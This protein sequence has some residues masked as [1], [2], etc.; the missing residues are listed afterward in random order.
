MKLTKCAF[1][2]LLLFGMLSSHV[3]AAQNEKESFAALF[4]AYAAKGVLT[5][6][7]ESVTI[8]EAEHEKYYIISSRGARRR[9][10]WDAVTPLPA[11]APRTDRP[12]GETVAY[13]A[14]AVGLQSKTD[15][16]LWTDLSRCLT[17]VL[18]YGDEGWHLIKT[19]SCSVGDAAHPTPR[20]RYEVDYKC[21]CIGKEGHYLCRYALCFYGSY[22]FH[23]VLYDF[24]GEKIIDERLGARISHGCVR[25][26]PTD[27]KWLYATIPVGTAVFIN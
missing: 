3:C 18:E 10:A 11:P 9:V 14:G 5:E 19:L 24:S 23:S 4:P 1:F 22:M 13:F 25:L 26:S 2:V 15:F 6:S 21:T 27:S 16:L 12:S 8:C 7:G 17:Y 20:G